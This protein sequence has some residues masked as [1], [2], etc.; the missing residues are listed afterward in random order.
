MFKQPII[1]MLLFI[2][3]LTKVGAQEENPFVAYDVPAQ[4]LFFKL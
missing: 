4:N 1:Y 2:M 3:V